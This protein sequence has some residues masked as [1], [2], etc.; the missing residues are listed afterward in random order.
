VTGRCGTPGWCAPE[1]LRA[2]PNARYPAGGL[3]LFSLG[4][5]VFTLLCGREPFHRV[6]VAETLRSNR[7]CELAFLDTQGWTG[8]S[9]P[10]RHFC[11]ALLVQEPR[12]R[13]TLQGALQHPWLRARGLDAPPVPRP[14]PAGQSQRLQ[15]DPPASNS[16]C[17]I[18]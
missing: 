5:A 4:V 6:D 11:R 13:I 10:A 14:R 2:K 16:S 1:L 17:V 18:T 7:N 12:D 8:V 15:S 9:E 3:D